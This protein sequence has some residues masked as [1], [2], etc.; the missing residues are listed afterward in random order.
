M[1]EQP[2][3]GAEEGARPELLLLDNDARIVELVSWFLTERGFSVRIASNFSEARA[4]IAERR[5]DLLISDVDLGAESATRELPR[6]AGEGILP[7]TLVVSGYLDTAVQAGLMELPEVLDT[8]SKPFE[9]PDLESKVRACLD[10]DASQDEPDTLVPAAPPRTEPS[11]P[12]TPDEVA[13][14]LLDTAAQETA[15]ETAEDDEGWIEI[16]P[17]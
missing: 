14:P 12:R 1:D 17:S 11:L 13:G 8:L 15:Q 10:A 6:L 5:P 16:T 2:H 3:G 4:A 7:R 9:F